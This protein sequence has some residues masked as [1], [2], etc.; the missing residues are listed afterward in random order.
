MVGASTYVILASAI[1]GIVQHPGQQRYFE[2]RGIFEYLFHTFLIFVYSFEQE[3]GHSQPCGC[4]VS[5]EL[6]VM[7]S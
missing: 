2:R 7:V 6:G 5:A 1:S 4:V 3:K